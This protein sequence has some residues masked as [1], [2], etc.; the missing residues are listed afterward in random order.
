MKD[1]KH[2]T[3]SPALTKKERTK[4]T[5]PYPFC[6]CEACWG[7]NPRCQQV[8]SVVTHWQQDPG[9]HYSTY[10]LGI[11]RLTIRAC[12]W[13]LGS[14][15]PLPEPHNNPRI[16]N[17]PWF[18]VRKTTIIF[19]VYAQLDAPVAAAAALSAPRW[20]PSE[21]CSRLNRIKGTE[22]GSVLQCCARSKEFLFAVFACVWGGSASVVYVTRCCVSEL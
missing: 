20:I 19:A 2:N 12:D 9:E 3:Q 6:S 16:V 22:G 18:L 11:S 1:I 10:W 8:G 4:I 21:G 5:L 14:A 7:R 17:N 15:K 13:V